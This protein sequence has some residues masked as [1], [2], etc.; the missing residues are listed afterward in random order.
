M[1]TTKDYSVSF[2]QG[3]RSAVEL[4][5]QQKGS[6]LAGTTDEEDVK[7]EAEFIDQVGIVDAEEIDS[8]YG[9]T[10]RMDPELDR[11]QLTTVGWDVASLITKKQIINTLDDPTNKYVIA[12]AYSLGRAQDQVRIDAMLGTAYTGKKGEN[13][14][15]LPSSQ[16]ILHASTG[17]TLAK[18][19][20]VVELMDDSDVPDEDRHIAVTAKQM[21]NLLN[22]TEVKSI[23]YNTVRAL[24]DGKI[25]TFLRMKFHRID[26]K[27]KDKTKIIP[28]L[29]AGIRRCVAWQKMGVLFGAGQNI[30]FDITKRADKR[31]ATQAYGSMDVGATRM[32]EPFVVEVQCQET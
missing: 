25:D 3:Y 13:A 1:S 4:L 20:N 32:Q 28:L 27:R 21:T 19:L 22:T 24:H 10:P 30:M 17:L 5:A 26:G 18:L 6:K 23:D 29:S 7:G 15:V 8:K 11:R 31:Y 12:Q 16:K 9:D 14:I 2:I